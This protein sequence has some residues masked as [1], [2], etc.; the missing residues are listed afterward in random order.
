MDAIKRIIRF[1]DQTKFRWLVPLIVIIILFI[2]V[3]YFLANE[4]V[5][6]FEY[7]IFSN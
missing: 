5:L 2:F 3:Y 6:P 1:V 4:G 7:K